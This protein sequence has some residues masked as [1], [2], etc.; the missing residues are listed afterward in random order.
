LAAGEGKRMNS[1]VP[2][3]MH[4]LFGKPLIDHVVSHVEQANIT[5]APVVVVSPNHTQVQGY[6]GTRARYVTQQE[7]LGTGHAVA[8]AHDVLK[9]AKHVMVLYGDMPFL[10][11]ASIMALAQTHLEE[12]NTITLATVKTQFEQGADSLL[13]D[14]GRIIRDEKGQIVDSV[15]LKDATPEQAAMT[16]VNPCYYCFD[17]AWLW[18]HAHKLE[19]NNAQGEYYLTD[20]VRLAVQEGDHLGSVDIEASEAIGINSKEDLMKAEARV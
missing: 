10:K 11:P 1:D 15:E 14:F 13:Y 4:L 2:K 5:D 8:T 16:E 18:E 3:V 9:D 19:R 17:A 7:Q 20:L 12:G 6:L